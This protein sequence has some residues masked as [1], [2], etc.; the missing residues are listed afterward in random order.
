MRARSHNYL[1]FFFR[2]MI[3]A[4]MSLAELAE[5]VE[6]CHQAS[7]NAFVKLIVQEREG[8]FADLTDSFIKATAI[9]IAWLASKV[10]FKDLKLNSDEFR[11]IFINF[12]TLKQ[13]F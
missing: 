10:L 9:Y 8:Q 7:Q 11:T 6:F 4:P 13:F 1:T 2:I 3:C 12:L 5:N